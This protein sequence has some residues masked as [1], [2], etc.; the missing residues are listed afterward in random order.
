M[1]L[2]PKLKQHTNVSFYKSVIHLLPFYFQH[3]LRIN[4]VTAIGAEMKDFVTTLHKSFSKKRDSGDE[5]TN[6]IAKKLRDV[7]Y[8][9]PLTWLV[10]GH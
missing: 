5:G 6:T 4:N 10:V 7:I 9:R 1:R 8:G 2:C 3:K